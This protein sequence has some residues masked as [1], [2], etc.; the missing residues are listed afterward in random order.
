[1]GQWEGGAPQKRKYQS[2]KDKSKEGQILVLNINNIVKI[3]SEDE[4]LME[5]TYLNVSILESLLKKI[6][7]I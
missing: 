6:K 1:M 3:T 4:Y 5:S 7:L 2:L